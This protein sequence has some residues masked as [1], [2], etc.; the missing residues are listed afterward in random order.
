MF[1]IILLLT[2]DLQE[3]TKSNLNPKFDWPYDNVIVVE[4]NS[5]SELISFSSSDQANLKNKEIKLI[6]EEKNK[7]KTICPKCSES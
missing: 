3:W 1:R 7:Y 5:G 6:E 4:F 2:D